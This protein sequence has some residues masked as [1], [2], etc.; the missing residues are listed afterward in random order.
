MSL[1]TRASLSVAALALAT[2]ACGVQFDPPSHLITLRALGVQKTEPYARPGASE[3]LSLLWY[4]GAPERGR[5]V[6]VTWIG[7]CTNPEGDVYYGC[8][9]QFAAAAGSGG[10]KLGHG[11]TFSFQVPPDIIAK[12]APPRDPRQPPYG[13]SFVY[14]ALCA[15]TLGFSAP[16]SAQDIP[17]RCRDAS[18]KDLGADDFV[19]GYTTVYVYGDVTNANPR[20]SG[21]E[22]D[23]KPVTPDCIGTTCVGRPVP[24]AVDCATA[25]AVCVPHC[26]SDPCPSIAFRPVVDPA[27]AEVDVVGTIQSGRTIGEQMWVDYYVDRGTVKSPVR[28]L[29]DAT[30]GFNADYGTELSIPTDPGPLT[31]WSVAHDSRGGTQWA[32]LTLG[33]Q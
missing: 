26:G 29:A 4:D 3:T 15:G 23:G 8:F 13:V 5:S 31:I 25:G 21:F 7:G 27:S 11:D 16:T 22:W 20:I 12:H 24:P 2:S 32:R 19:V 33:V 17:L 10:L 1:R 28:L 6:S 9:P 18:G 30:K 14:F